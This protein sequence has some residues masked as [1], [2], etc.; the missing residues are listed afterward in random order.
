[1]HQSP[2]CTHESLI[3][4][5]LEQIVDHQIKME[6]KKHKAKID[7]RNNSNMASYGLCR[8]PLRGNIEFVPKGRYNKK[9][10]LHETHNVS[11]SS[12]QIREVNDFFHIQLAKI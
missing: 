5:L 6:N 9:P 1:M 7:K 12:D 2:L 3:H 10:S 11:P 4:K 8:C